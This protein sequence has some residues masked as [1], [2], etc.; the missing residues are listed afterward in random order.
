MVLAAY[1]LGKC[2]L[3]AGSVL[4]AGSFGRSVSQSFVSKI[5][6]KPGICFAVVAKSPA[7]S[8]STHNVS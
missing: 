8:T 5:S 4:A 3:K 6:L 7:S 1:A 2:A